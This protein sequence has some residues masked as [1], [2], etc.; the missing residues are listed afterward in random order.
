LLKPAII[1]SIGYSFIRA[2]TTVSAVIFLATAGT[3]VATTFILGR[4]EDGDYGVSVAYGSVL[5]L[6]MLIFTL[7]VQKL[8]GSSRTER[9]VKTT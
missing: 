3:S 9:S 6:A 4:V 2:M 5:I 7:L 1:S 8:V